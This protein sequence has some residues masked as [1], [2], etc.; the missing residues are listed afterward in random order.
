VASSLPNAAVLA[1]D[2]SRASLA[3]ASRE[4]AARGI[5]NIAFAQ[6][7]LLRLADVDISFDMIEC[8]GVLHHLEE[9]EA[10]LRALVS[11]LRPGGH[12]KIGLYSKVAREAII[13]ARARF[14]ESGHDDDL[15]GIR[16]F[17]EALIAAHDDTLSSLV[18]S[19][20]FF[21]TSEFRDMVMH[22][23]EHQ[24]TLPA[25]DAMLKRNGL[26]FLGFCSQPA[27]S[28][29]A[30]MPARTA[31]RSV[32]DLKVWHRLE[33]RNPDLFRGMYQFVCVKR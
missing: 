13:R 3:Y 17:R 16:A 23:Q 21:A 20:D 10:G 19:R 5:D 8:I 30:R 18:K 4:A 29:L 24:F 25:I 11:V 1:I 32:R 22:V 2:L 28:L 27:R 9:P 33:I 26:K 31:E 14:A 6:A 12:I 7:D 15:D